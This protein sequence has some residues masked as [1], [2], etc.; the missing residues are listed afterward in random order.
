MATA[1]STTPVT[2]PTTIIVIRKYFGCWF[3]TD[4]LG[5][6]LTSLLWKYKQVIVVTILYIQ[7][8]CYLPIK[9][10]EARNHVHGKQ[11]KLYFCCCIQPFL[12]PHWTYIYVKVVVVLF[13]S[14]TCLKSRRFKNAIYRKQQVEKCASYSNIKIENQHI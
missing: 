6:P 2:Q 4:R 10:S 3:S 12:Q 7:A 1:V 8:F 14:T 9:N 5:C 13:I 11:Q